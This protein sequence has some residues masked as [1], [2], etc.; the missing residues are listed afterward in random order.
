MQGGKFM[1]NRFY[2]TGFEPQGELRGLA[3]SQIQV[4]LRVAPSD[5]NWL[6]SVQSVASETY[7]AR[8]DLYSVHGPFLADSSAGTPQDAIVQVLEKITVQLKNWREKQNRRS[9]AEPLKDP[10]IPRALDV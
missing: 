2:F 3:E 7:L 9:L 6:G 4:L 10:Y 5:S 8:F 1:L